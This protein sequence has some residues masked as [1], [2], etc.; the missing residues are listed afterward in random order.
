MELKDI[1]DYTG[2]AADSIDDFKKN[3]ETTFVKKDAVL[4]DKEIIDKITGKRMGSLATKLKSNLTKFGIE[5]TE[6]VIQKKPLEEVID[7]AFETY[8]ENTNG[9]ITDLQEK[10]KLNS[11]E[12][13]KEIQEKY[14]KLESKF[15]DTVKASKDIANEFNL[16]KTKAAD[17][18][19]NVKITTVKE[20]A[21]GKI[22]KRTD[23][24]DV[25]WIGFQAIAD[26]KF[27]VDLDENNQPFIADKATGERFRNPAKAG[28]FLSI[29]DVLKTEAATLGISPKNPH[30]PPN[31]YV[32]PATN[33]NGHAAPPPTQDRPMASRKA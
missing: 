26:T 13:T 3:F 16:F 1:L 8:T 23:I 29:E 28:E 32:A 21:F 6:D 9:T 11:G 31:P 20:Q 15:N 7:I 4:K 17:D 12:Q 22:T 25:E 27:K 10:L 24:K 5:L 18:L 2:I 30:R 33:G 19:K 14:T